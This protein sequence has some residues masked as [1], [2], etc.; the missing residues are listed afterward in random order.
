MALRKI[1]TNDAPCLR[2]VSK[3]VL[4]FDERLHRLLEDMADTLYK[5]DGVGL[6]AP[7]IGILKRIVV[8]DL[9][10]GSGLLEMINPAIVSCAGSQ[11]GPEA[12][13]SFPR[14]HGIVTRPNEV[15][16]RFQDRFGETR[17]LRGEGLFARAV[18][19][20]TDHLQGKVYLDIATDL[21]FVPAKEESE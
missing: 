20:E 10:D 7:Q 5:A 17:E 1:F 4:L 19:H 18:C 9:R 8:I 2:K 3:P 14:L 15:T 11:T 13:L 16:V 12:C 6:A 21:Q